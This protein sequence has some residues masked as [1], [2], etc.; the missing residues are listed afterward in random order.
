MKDIVVELLGKLISKTKDYS[1]QWKHMSPRIRIKPYFKQDDRIEHAHDLLLQDMEN[2][3]YSDF[4]DG[5]FFLISHEGT[6]EVKLIVQSASSSR[7]VQYASTLDV[8]NPN[9]ISELKR[10]YNLVDSIDYDV[11]VFVARFLGQD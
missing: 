3:Y 2:S 10:L 4:E 11:S 8:A 1:I 5:R 9:I 7:S 6:H